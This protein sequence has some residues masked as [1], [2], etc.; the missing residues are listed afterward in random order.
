MESYA[1]VALSSCFKGRQKAS[2]KCMCSLLGR[3]TVVPDAVA[4]AGK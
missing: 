3:E 1:T 2:T 4:G